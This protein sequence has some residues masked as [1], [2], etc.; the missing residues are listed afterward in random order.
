MFIEWVT[1]DEDTCQTPNYDDGVCISIRNCPALLNLLR[2]KPIQRETSQFLR[3]SQCGFEGRYPKVCCPNSG[4]TIGR[5]TTPK[6]PTPDYQEGQ[7]V[8]S[9]LLP[10]VSVCG[11]GTN[12]RIYGG[13][14]AEIDDFPWMA[15]LEYKKRMWLCFLK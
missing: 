13:E 11:L 14:V 10:D 9:R 7:A 1:E 2:S 12:N 15:L 8:Y 6:P 5:L 3:L 4:Q